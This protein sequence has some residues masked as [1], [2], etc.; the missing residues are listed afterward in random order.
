MMLKLLPVA[1][2]LA[3]LVIA[4][5]ASAGLIG[6]TAS[7][8][9]NGVTASVDPGSATVVAGTPEFAYSVT[10]FN[11][12]TGNV[13][14][15]SFTLA[16]GLGI[17]SLGD[18]GNQITLTLDPGA[19]PITG[20]NATVTGFTDFAASDIS[21]SGNTL[22]FALGA[23]SARVGASVVVDFTFGAPDPS[24]VPEPASLA[25]L[26]AELLGLVALARRRRA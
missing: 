24:R 21:L 19:T 6:S 10:G 13:E 15:S 23:F 9:F 22:T 3:A 14:A 20:I 18:P 2:L 5:P 11:I 7:S 8:T 17:L 16:N 26:G 25:L 12:F 4:A 1:S